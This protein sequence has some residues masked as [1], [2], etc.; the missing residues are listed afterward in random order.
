MKK[1]VLWAVSNPGTIALILLAMA[2]SL[3]CV[4]Q[5]NTHRSST[6]SA[7]VGDNWI[8]VE[9]SVQSEDYLR[10]IASSGSAFVIVGSETILRSEDGLT[11]TTMSNVYGARHV[12]CDTSQFYMY[13][14]VRFCYTSRDGLDWAKHPSNYLEP[15]R[16]VQWHETGFIA[17][18]SG[19]Q[20]MSLIGSRNGF[21]W[22]GLNGYLSGAF[23]SI[24]RF[25][26]LYVGVGSDRRIK[27]SRDATDWIFSDTIV[28]YHL[29]SVTH[30]GRKY[31][32]VGLYGVIAVSEDGETWHSTNRYT[33]SDLRKV[34]WT[35]EQFIAVGGQRDYA[36]TILTSRD[37]N[38]WTIAYD[39]LGGMLL[40]VECREDICIAI[41]ANGQILISRE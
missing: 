16:F 19:M 17:A 36:A 34:V 20:I 24:V 30:N 4:S 5:C 7:I 38:K 3:T 26:S 21:E 32:A 31:V 2:C 8:A 29:R 22:S 18:H 11:W 10:S 12:V 13:P 15:L 33:R 23:F 35:G 41:G 28:P 27:T 37:G 40:D 25:D 6:P 1:R 14:D 9:Q 39:T